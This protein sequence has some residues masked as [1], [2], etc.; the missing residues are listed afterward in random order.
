[1]R[2]QLSSSSYIFGA[3]GE[4]ESAR[5]AALYFTLYTDKNAHIIFGGVFKMPGRLVDCFWL[6]LGWFGVCALY[7]SMPLPA[8]YMVNLKINTRRH[9]HCER[10]QICLPHQSMVAKSIN[11]KEFLVFF[12]QEK[13]LKKIALD[14]RIF[15]LVGK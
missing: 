1:M 12:Y 9:F 13:Q 5:V 15:I 7:I 11:K 10:L 3:R 4:K 8:G 14:K 2:Y 6:C